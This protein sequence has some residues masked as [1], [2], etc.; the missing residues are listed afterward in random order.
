MLHPFWSR[1]LTINRLTL[2]SGKSSTIL[3]LL[4]LL[5]PLPSKSSEIIIDSISLHEIDRATL[6]RRIIAVPQDAVF[7][8]DGTSFKT[9]LDPFAAASD[10]DCRAV[11]EAV[12][13]WSFVDSRGGLSAGLAA[14]T[15]S[16]GQK[17]LFSLARAILRRRIRAKDLGLQIEVGVESSGDTALSASEDGRRKASEAPA[18]AQ[19]GRTQQ[20]GILLLDEVSSSVDVDTDRA[21]QAII[22]REFEGYTIVMVSHRLEMVME[23]DKVLVM[24][25]GA[26]V[27]AGVPRELVTVEG[28]RFRELWMV[29]N[30]G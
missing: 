25:S 12:D 18:L 17:Q 26:V 10:A 4:R 28:G 27:E 9:N 6:R 13:L 14:D 11:L 7:L 8:P 16:Q 5:D 20:G 24:D 2:H 29:G 1:F 19:T 21:M 3:L 30:Q 15:L 22:R 23:F